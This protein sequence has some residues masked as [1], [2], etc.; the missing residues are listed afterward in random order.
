MKKS[1]TLFITIVLTLLLS[2][3]NINVGQLL[4]YPLNGDALDHS[5]NNNNGTATNLIYGVDRL[6]NPNSAAYFNGTNSYISLPN[7]SSLKPQLPVTISFWVKVDDVFAFNSEFFTTDYLENSFSGVFVNLNPN[8]RK[9][10]LSIGSADINITGPS[11]RRSKTG[12]TSIS[13]NVWYH[14]TG[15]VNGINNMSIYINC[16]EDGGSYDGYA[17]SL[18]Y[19]N[20]PGA[21]GVN[22]IVAYYPFHFKGYLDEVRY[23]DRALTSEEVREL[24]VNSTNIVNFSNTNLKLTITPNPTNESITIIEDFKTLTPE[25]VIFNTLGQEIKKGI[26]DSQKSIKVSEL[27]NGVYFINIVDDNK[28]FSG[29]FIKN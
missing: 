16:L 14:V 15:I 7:D 2:G 22:D 3:Q 28:I 18:G 24:C 20:M 8:S 4:Y 13:S 17:T 25:Y 29:K 10:Q 11:N 5:G 27:S 21:V 9:I 23:W 26:I 6:G 1:F 19:T 12:T